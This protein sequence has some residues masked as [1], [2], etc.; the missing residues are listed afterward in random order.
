MS[1]V[2]SPDLDG[3]GNQTVG[4]KRD[5]DLVAVGMA[6]IETLM[7]TYGTIFVNQDAY[8]SMLGGILTITIWQK[9]VFLDECITTV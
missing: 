8:G 5:V 3:E 7:W 4:S 9:S 1:T 2:V 6:V